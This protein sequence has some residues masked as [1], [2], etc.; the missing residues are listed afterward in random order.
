MHSTT[1]D[2]QGIRFA[3]VVHSFF[4]AFRVFAAVF[5][6]QGIH[7]YHFLAYFVASFAIQKGIQTLAGADTVV[8]AAGGANVLVLL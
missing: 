7:R 6:L 8:V 5:E 1:H 3:C 4:E 2:H